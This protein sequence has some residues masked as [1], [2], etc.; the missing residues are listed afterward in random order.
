MKLH[1][2]FKLFKDTIFSFDAPGKDGGKKE[3]MESRLANFGY[4]G[5]FS[6]FSDPYI[7]H[8]I[9]KQTFEKTTI[10]FASFGEIKKEFLNMD[11]ITVQRISLKGHWRTQSNYYNNLCSLE[12]EIIG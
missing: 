7:F 5:P 12:I 2:F 10:S 4:V 9:N 1:D 11:I 3:E 8:V 6:K